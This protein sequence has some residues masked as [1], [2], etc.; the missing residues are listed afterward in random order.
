VNNLIIGSV[1]NILAITLVAAAPVLP[2]GTSAARAQSDK[3]PASTITLIVPFAPGG[4][5]DI[6]AR[7]LATHVSEDLGQP[8]VIDNRAGGAGNIGT[9]AA[10]RAKPD[11]YTL[12]LATTT[13][14]I[15]QYLMKDLQ[16][17]LFTDLV[18]VALIADAPELV[19]ITSKLPAK[20]LSEFVAAA[21]AEPTGFNYGSAGIGSVPHLGGEVMAR[22]MQAKLV[23]IPFRGSA[24]AAKEVASGNVQ[25]TLATQ[26]SLAS[27]VEAGL[28]RVV[29]VAAPQRMSTLS[30]VPTT[31]EAGL[32]GV[33]LS[34]WFGIMAPRNIPPSMVLRL[35]ESFNKALGV[36]A[37]QSALT[38][39]G[40]EPVRNTP[41]RFAARLQTDGQSYK[42]LVNEIGLTPK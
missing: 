29:A 10:A 4:A 27:F 8:V 31:A 39:Q 20:T 13:Q 1:R 42:K 3:F 7:L 18:P 6:V 41:K 30:N 25:M 22:A 9:A 24:D 32:P 15:N 2:G 37:V 36:P 28:I 38:R 17:D 5:T 26:A 12:V 11:G 35:N 33:E 23:H 16:Y 19:G 14:L 34:N 21:R 40:I